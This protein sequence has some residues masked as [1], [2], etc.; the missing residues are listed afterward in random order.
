M[1]T[2]DKIKAMKFD[3]TK[4]KG[5]SDERGFVYLK[6]KTLA[7]NKQRHFAFAL[8]LALLFFTIFEGT[9]FT[10]FSDSILR[11]DLLNLL[12]TSILVWFIGIVIEYIQKLNPKR[13]FDLY[14]AHIMM[15][16][17]LCMCTLLVVW[18]FVRFY[19]L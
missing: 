10:N 16:G 12:V 14:D 8:F 15:I 4:L 9:K 19:V 2:L 3:W 6:D 11:N 18:R 17:A 7:F 1:N 13:N 5:T